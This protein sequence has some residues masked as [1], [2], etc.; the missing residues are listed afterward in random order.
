MVSRIGNRQLHY[1]IHGFI[2]KGFFFPLIAFFFL[3][4]MCHSDLMW[5]FTS[6]QMV[7]DELLERARE[8]E[9]K[10]AK[11][12]KCLA[13]DFLNLLQSIKV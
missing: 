1:C 10:E 4:H 9:E 13:D 8:K 6:L 3:K 11:K 7:F 5:C 12:R 2:F